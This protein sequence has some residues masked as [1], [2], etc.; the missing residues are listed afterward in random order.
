MSDDRSAAIIGHTG[1]VGSN[2]LRQR[3]FDDCFNSRNIDQIDGRSFDLLIVSGARAEKWKANA[4][5]ERDLDNIE[6]LFKALS[7]VN[8]RKVVL[9]STVD[10]FIQPVG[11]DEDSPTPM[12]GLHAYGRHRRRLE[13]LV[14]ARFDA[15]VV[16]LAALYGPG[17]KKNV[18][19]DFLH[20]N[21]VRKI[22]S[23]AVFQFYDIGRLWRDIRIAMNNELPLV[24]LP[25][26]PVTAAEV[27]RAAFDLDFE[28]EVAERPARY[29]VQTRYAH[30]FGGEGRY[31]EDKPRE[32]Q[33]IAEFVRQERS[34]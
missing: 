3:S 20:D 10:V 14:S 15:L 4:E 21:D 25:T 12:D 30:L 11:V 29:D 22:D 7:H 1:F 6:Q 5:P 2:L 16:R 32:L 27:A 13:Q 8:A 23:R 17:L 34:K 26:E 24:H 33:G 19:F 28:N 31:V 9:I 18:I